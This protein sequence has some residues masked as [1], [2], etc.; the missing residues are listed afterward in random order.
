MKIESKLS[1]VISQVYQAPTL[2]IAK[3]ILIPFLRDSKIKESDKKKMIETAEKISQL[4]LLQYYA[5]NALL[6]YESLGL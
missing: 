4:G 1:E 2:N 5:T 6:K 3:S